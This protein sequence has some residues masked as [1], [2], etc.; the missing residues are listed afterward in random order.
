MRVRTLG[1]ACATAAAIGFGSL[2]ARSEPP[3]EAPRVGSALVAGAGATLLPFVVG[4]GLA[5]GGA[6]LTTKNA[7]VV[8]ANGSFVLGPIVAHAVVGEWGRGLAFAGVPAA[9][10]AV[11]AVL[12]AAEPQTVFGDFGPAPELTVVF[13]ASSFVSAVGVVD[14]AFAGERARAHLVP[15]VGPK[16]GGVELAVAW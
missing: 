3:S 7:G 6:D 11:N 4:A 13:V 12:L 8:M 9:G 2:P 5:A 10:T 14:A 16:G 1:T 15:R